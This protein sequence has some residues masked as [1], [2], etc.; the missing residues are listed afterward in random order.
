MSTLAPQQTLAAAASA[1]PHDRGAVRDTGPARGLDLSRLEKVRT[2]NGKTIAR[3]PACAESG[4]DVNG[5]HLFIDADGPFGCVKFPGQEGTEHRK[6]VFALA[7]VIEKREGP[8][9]TRAPQRK[10]RTWPDPESA[11]KACTPEGYTLA[12]VYHY[13]RDGK[14]FAAV[15]RY[16]NGDGKTFRQFTMNGDGWK[17]GGPAGAWPLYCIETLPAEGCAWIVEGEKA[18]AAAAS[19]G[20]PSVTSAGGSGAADKTDWTC[21]AGREV[22]ILPD[23][24]EPGEGYARAVSAILAKLNPPARVRIVRLPMTEPGGDIADFLDA[25]DATEPA[26]LRAEIETLAANAEPSDTAKKATENGAPFSLVELAEQPIDPAETLIGAGSCRYV[27]R[28]AVLLLAAP[29]GVGKSHLAAQGAVSWSCGR[30][31]FGLP[32]TMPLRCLI[33]Q[34]ENPPNDS[35]SIART[36][37][38]GLALSASERAAVHANTLQVWLPGCAGEPFLIEAARLL[39]AWPADL[40][41]VDPLAGFADGDLVRPEVVQRFC[42]GGLS[43][44]AVK[45]RCALFVCHHVPKPNAQR[46]ASRMG[47]YDHQY[48]G[49]G[50]ADL[51]ANWPRAVLTMQAIARG[52]FILRAAKRR[53]PWTTPDGMQAWEI[54][55]RHTPGGTWET[56][57]VDATTARTGRPKAPDPETF[58]AAVLVLLRDAGAMPKTALESRIRAK[59]TNSRDGA[60]A[61]LELLQADGS[62]VAW[63]GAGRGGCTMIGLPAEVPKGET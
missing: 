54:G 34:A 38:E 55:L 29:S 52:E 10:A 12:A 16:E 57:E 63:R 35:R 40:V 47:T 41:F 11:A 44:L 18:H 33:L 30:V 32:P 58:R 51:V 26:A 7:G 62:L 13:P 36:M 23:H 3:C 59:V 50:S 28:G 48:A 15:G 6:R 1:C 19:I 46:D 43:A 9:Q 8:R 22:C 53:P 4:G 39:K 14:P 45:H 21:L 27:E 17:A 20:L 61:V 2:V 42:R 49:A 25:R 31:A 24:D 37:I 56:C 60:R 5:E